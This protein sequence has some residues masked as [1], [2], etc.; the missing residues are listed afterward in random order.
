[1]SNILIE[2]YGQEIDLGV[3]LIGKNLNIFTLRG[4]SNLE[5]L[6]EISG[7]DVY[8]DV[9]NPEGTQRDL[10]TKHSK[11]ALEYALDSLS[12]NPAENPRAFPELTLNVRD[13][14]VLRVFDMN[15]SEIN[16]ESTDFISENETK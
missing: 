1:M 2:K 4:F 13:A 11:E 3:C 6:A 16:F 14:S 10:K 7:G 12:E 9:L 8:D 15:N 5:L